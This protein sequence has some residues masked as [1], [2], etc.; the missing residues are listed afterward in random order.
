MKPKPIP[1]CPSCGHPKVKARR[2][3]DEELMLIAKIPDFFCWNTPKC[4]IAIPMEKVTNW[5]V[6]E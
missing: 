4:Q 5:I 6:G 2:I 3:L 1:L